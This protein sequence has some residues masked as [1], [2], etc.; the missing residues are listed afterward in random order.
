MKQEEL[1]KRM[2]MDA[3]NRSQSEIGALMRTPLKQAAINRSI[4]NGNMT[5]NRLWEICEVVGYEIV[6]QPKTKG[7]RPDKQLVFTGETKSDRAKT[8]NGDA[9]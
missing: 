1:I 9:E 7:K 6:V 4:K 8:L 5:I 3:G 2:L